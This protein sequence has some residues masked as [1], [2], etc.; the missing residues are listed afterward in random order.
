MMSKIT[1]KTEKRPTKVSDHAISRAVEKAYSTPT[2]DGKYLRRNHSGTL[3]SGSALS[4]SRK[5]K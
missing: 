3:P 1:L 2:G 4:P 5:K